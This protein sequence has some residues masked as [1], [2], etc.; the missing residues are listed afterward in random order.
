MDVRFVK[1]SPTQ[2][3]T[4]LV[5]DAVA[6]DQQPDVAAKLL[7]YDGVGGEQ[8]GFLEKPSNPAAQLRL[9][10][11]GDEFCGNGTMSAGAY[12]AWKSGL[13]NGECAEYWLEVSGATELVRCR[14]ERIGDAYCGTVRM[15]LPERIEET[16]LE[17]DDGPLTLPIVALP[18]IAHII[19]PAQTGVSREEIEGRIR[20]WNLNIRAE[21]L[22]VLRYD[23]NQQNME[24]IVYVPSVDSAVWERGCGSGTAA[25]GCWLAKREGNSVCQTLSQPGGEIAVEVFMEN[26]EI[27]SAAI[28]GTVR[29]TAEGRAFL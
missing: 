21:A 24:P 4:I 28:T 3:V 22:G 9:Q 6:R 7:A 2:N 8:V 18:G 14:I 11:A 12:L 5:E 20:S 29:I 19:M 15:P 27:V 26:D 13:Q 25:L 10:M 16:T 23:E 17:T 1:L